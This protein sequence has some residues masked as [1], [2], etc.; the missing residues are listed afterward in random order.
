MNR[1][2]SDLKKEKKPPMS[3]LEVRN[4]RRDFFGLSAVAGVDLHVGDG[5]IV[6][7][8]GPNGAGKTTTFNLISGTIK[9][10]AGNILFKGED[11]TALKPHEICRKNIARTFQAVN[12]MYDMTVFENVLIGSLFGALTNNTEA[13]DE[14]HAILDFMGLSE[15]KDFPADD[16][17]I[18][19]QK[20]LEIARALATKPEVLLLDEVMAGLIPSEV[21]A[22]VEMVR[23]INNK[24]ITLFLIEHIMHAIME[25]SDRIIVLH[26]G[27][28]IAEGVPEEITKDKKVIEVYLG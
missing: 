18:A 20:R 5:E 13:R 16:L 22:M 6:G 10:T 26:Y 3:L 4:L 24:G 23:K 2:E 11:I 28:K 25:V 21:S 9:P 1:E 7:L 19:E 17:G 14:A 27:E 12:L 8:I 15:K